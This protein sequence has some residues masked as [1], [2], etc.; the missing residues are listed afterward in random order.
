[1]QNPRKKEQARK[2]LLFLRAG[3]TGTG[4]ERPGWLPGYPRGDSMGPYSATLG[5]FARTPEL[6]L[7]PLVVRPPLRPGLADDAL[8][9]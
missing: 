9:E 4:P 8:E 3:M 6:R 5:V 1:M 7:A 2:P